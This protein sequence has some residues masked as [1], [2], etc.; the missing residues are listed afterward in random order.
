MKL[1]SLNVALFEDNNSR[2]TK[3]LHSEKPDII[4]LQ[5]VVREIEETVSPE[6]V[7]KGPVDRVTQDLK[8]SFY[9]PNSVM[10]NFDMEDFH[11]QEHFRF[12]LGGLAEMGNYVRS[13][14]KIVKGQN[15]FLE[16]HF[17]YTTDYS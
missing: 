9:G 14:F 5:E 10:Q 17:T 6:F 16:N 2:L 3:F 4:C 8:Y 12:D 11:G 1:L 7:T 15:I 13:K